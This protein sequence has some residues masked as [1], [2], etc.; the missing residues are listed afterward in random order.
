MADS[1]IEVLG[2]WELLGADLAIVTPAFL[3]NIVASPDL[4]ARCPTAFRRA[5]KFAVEVVCSNGVR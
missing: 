2:L 5:H 3:H 1:P 4:E